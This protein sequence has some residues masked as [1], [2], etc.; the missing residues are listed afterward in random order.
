MT[1]SQ[2]LGIRR[3]RIAVQRGMPWDP[4]AN[5]SSLHLSSNDDRRRPVRVPGA[6]LSLLGLGKLPEQRAAWMGLLLAVSPGVAYAAPGDEPEVEPSV[7]VEED[8]TDPRAPS[9]SEEGAT[10]PDEERKEGR[11]EDSA[12]DEVEGA[13]TQDEVS[14]IPPAVL[15]EAPV[16]L[17][18]GNGKS[19]RVLLLVTVEAD[20]SVQNVAVREGLSQAIDDAAIAA[21]RRWKFAPATRDGQP[22]AARIFVAIAVKAQPKPAPGPVTSPAPRQTPPEVPHPVAAHEHPDEDHAHDDDVHMQVTVHGERPLRTE[23][24]SASDYYL[25]REVLQAAPH[26]EGAD[27][28]RAAPGVTVFRTEGLAQAHSYSLRGFDAEHG[29][30]IEFVVGGLPINLPSHIHGQGYSDL[31]FL[32]GEVVDHVYVSEGV[33]DPS[34]GD[35]AVAGSIKIGLGVD[36]EHRGL[37]VRSGYGSFNTQRHQ[38]IWAPKEAERES[39]GAAQF[40]KTDGFG[41][42]RAGQSGSGIIQHRFGQ[43][44]VRYRAIGLVHAAR[45][46]VAGVLR[47]DDIDS[48][49]V[50]FHCAYPDATAQAQ[51]ALAQRLMAG[52]FA[53]YRG[54]AHANGT[55]GF[56]VGRDHYRSQQNFT[57]YLEKSQLLSLVSGRGDLIEQRN[58]TTTWG[59][60]GRYRTEAFEPTPWA[61]GTLEVGLD[62]RLDSISQSQSLLDGGVRNQVW[63]ERVDAEITGVNTGLWGDLDWQ[64]G[65]R[66]HV[67]AGLRAAALS[68]DVNDRLG[69][70]APSGRPQDQ[71][72]PG[73]RR[74]AMGATI[75][76]RTSFEV[77]AL[78]WLRVLGSYGEGYRSPQARLLQDGERAPFAKVRSVDGGVRFRFGEPFDL[79]VT[80]YSTYLSDDVVFDA[81]EGRLERVGATRRSGAVA[82]ALSRPTEWLLSSFSIT[83]VNTALLEPPP[84]TADE[85]NPP[86]ERGSPLPFVS[87]LIVRLDA[88]VKR[89]LFGPGTRDPLFGRAGLGV[90]YLA[91]PAL[92]YNQVADPIPLLDASVGLLW[93]RFEFDVSAFNLLDLDYAARQYFFVSNWDA[94]DVPSRIPARHISAGSPLSV[95]AT[96]GVKL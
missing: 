61:H 88:S 5:A 2:D 77:K 71:A 58:D 70:R 73:F 59:L 19:G 96:L 50:C 79:L 95:M 14:V 13:D 47:V 53:D 87:P 86:F 23:Q 78:E 65:S 9:E 38:L 36:E 52:F 51:S 40:T 66:V 92:P 84:A 42:G 64:F 29:Q 8:P 63:D 48:G 30:D 22:I 56:Y 20:G 57:G 55:F 45:A 67:R 34:Q 41:E 68:Y 12:R 46:N 91:A 24:R 15:E 80:G 72:L 4:S 82:Y 76:P 93:N 31:G 44:D 54:P 37:Q 39:L 43:G 94:S 10:P 32:L 26:Q 11:A 17:P 60:V 3:A 18:E 49:E 33:S 74:S 35:F 28:L 81:S 1:G 89:T 21:V 6:V 69:N 85:P 7:S 16:E 27:V 25:H 90:T 62:G 83:Y 75:G